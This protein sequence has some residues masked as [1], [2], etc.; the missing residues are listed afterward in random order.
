MTFTMTYHLRIDRFLYYYGIV[1]DTNTL[2]D[3]LQ[4]WVSELIVS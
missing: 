1:L 3:L 4:L 2:I